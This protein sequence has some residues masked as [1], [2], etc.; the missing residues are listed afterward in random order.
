MACQCGHAIE[1]HG[2]DRRH[3]GSTAC[4]ECDCI[5]FE[6]NDDE[7]PY[8]PSAHCPL[9]ACRHEGCTRLKEMCLSRR[10]CP[11]ITER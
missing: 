3:L 6:E 11:N 8:D 4:T 9:D 10:P 1:E 7:E 2:N 5:A